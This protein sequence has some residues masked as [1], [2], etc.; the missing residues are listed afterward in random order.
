MLTTNKASKTV[1]VVLRVDMVVDGERME[2]GD[3]VEM[4]GHNFK[5]LI[6]HDRVAEATAENIAAVRAEIKA[7]EEAAKRAAQPSGEDVLKARI[8][9]LEAELAATKKK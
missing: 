7:T 6:Q 5:Y 8:A 3:V 9:N 1:N 2:K 4:S